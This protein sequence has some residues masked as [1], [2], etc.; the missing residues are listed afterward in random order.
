M[1]NDLLNSILRPSRLWIGILLAVVLCLA[2]VWWWVEAGW[3]RQARESALHHLRTQAQALSGEIRSQWDQGGPLAV[4]CPRSLPFLVQIGLPGGGNACPL[5]VSRDT[6]PAFLEDI[7]SGAL[8]GKDLHRVAPF[9]GFSGGSEADAVWISVPVRAGGQ[10]VA[11]I[12]MKSE[13]LIPRGDITRLRWAFVLAGL[14]LVGAW[15]AAGAL[16][17]SSLRKNLASLLAQIS[18]W[19]DGH[20]S[21]R[22]PAAKIPWS[23]MHEGLNRLASQM[24]QRLSHLLNRLNEGEAVWRSMVE[25]VVAVD[26]EGGLIELNR[27]AAD[28]FQAD[29]LEGRGRPLLESVRNPELVKFVEETLSAT[30]PTEGEIILYGTQPRFLQVHGTRLLDVRGKRLGALIVLNDVTRLRRLEGLRREF[31]ANVSHE[32]KTPITSIQGFVE[33]LQ[34]GA[35]EDPDE[36]HRFLGIISRQTE[37]LN[38]IIEDLLSLSRIEQEAETGPLNMARAP[39]LPVLE[40]AIGLCAEKAEANGSEIVLDCP[41]GLEIRMNSRLIEQAVV[42]LTDN[43]VKYGGK[44]GRVEISG[45]LTGGRI[46]ISVKDFGPGIPEGDQERLFERFYRVD[47]GRSRSEGGTGLGLAIVKHIVQAHGGSVAVKSRLGDGS[48]FILSFPMGQ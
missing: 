30:T 37:R 45:R 2:P 7:I 22:L 39:L 44:D 3:H 29:P 16:F 21:E 42:N 6:P 40:S 34:D 8:A 17:R 38:G 36:A 9:S 24:D 43:A 1:P 20:F 27:A 41:S 31:V 33:T 14:C 11:A 46:E 5:K 12:L 10:V 26:S 28:L 25:G 18:R 47:K 13:I 15:G 19:E 23:G 32:L 35:L 48:T 4:L